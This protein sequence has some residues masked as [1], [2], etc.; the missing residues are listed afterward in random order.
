MGSVM[1][2]MIG[3]KLEL[4]LD[5]AVEHH[6]SNQADQQYGRPGDFLVGD[7]AVH[8]T[9]APSEG[10]IRKCADNV[11]AGLRPIIVTL[12]DKVTTAQTLAENQSLDAYIEVLDFEGFMT[13]NI[14]ERSR[15]SDRAR[16]LRVA[17]LVERYNAIVERV[18]PV[19]GI[20]LALKRE[21][22]ETRS[23]EQE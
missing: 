13:A 5:E 10:L 9:T 8:V 16:S 3:A 17:D 1:Q 7:C 23:E 22:A 6:S 2:H 19:R 12:W 4:A 21:A 14:L 15:F 20:K 18:D 11:E